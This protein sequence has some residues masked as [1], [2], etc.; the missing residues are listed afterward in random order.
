ML[1]KRATIALLIPVFGVLGYVYYH[2]NP[3]SGGGYFPSCP[4]RSILKIYCPGCGSQRAVHYMLH[5]EFFKAFRYNPFL[6]TSLPFLLV[7]VAQWFYE[8]ATG[9]RWGIGLF[10]RPWFLRGLFFIICIYFVARNLPFAFLD[11]LRPPL[12]AL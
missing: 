8:W 5:G 6:V 10:T 9:K 1:S 12:G 7:L 4:T 2:Y 3:A 11:W